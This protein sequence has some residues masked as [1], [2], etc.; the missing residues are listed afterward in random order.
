MIAVV[1]W[2]GSGKTTLLEKL[3]ACLVSRG[4]RVATLKHSHHDFEI[5]RPGKDSDRLRRAGA[6]QVVLASPYRTALIIEEDGITDPGDDAG[7]TRLVGQLDSSRLDLVLVEGFRHCRLPKLE[8]SRP[9]LNTPLICEQDDQ[10]IAV[11]SDDPSLA[12]LP[13]I[14][15][16]GLTLLPLNDVDKIC[17]FIISSFLQ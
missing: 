5:D 15:Q 7:L 4:Y 11:A 9:A 17:D 3:V 8:V 12:E 2:S 14:K 16:R 13:V 10:V 6:S 1:A